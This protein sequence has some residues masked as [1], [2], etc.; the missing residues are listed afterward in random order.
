MIHDT[1]DRVIHPVWLWSGVLLLVVGTVA[2]Q[3]ALVLAAAL[4]LGVVGVAYLWGRRALTAVSYRRHLSQERAAWGDGV[5]LSVRVENRKLLPLPWLCIEDEMPAALVIRTVLTSSHLAERRRLRILSSVLWYQQVTRRYTLLCTARGEHVF[6]PAELRSG[7]IFGLATAWLTLPERTTLL[8]YP[9]V[10]SPSALG[11][12]PAQPFGPLRTPRRLFDDPLRTVGIRD[13]AVG[14]SLRSMH[15]KATARTGAPQVRVPEPVRTLRAVIFLDV[16]TGEH[17][18]DGYDPDLLELA[19]VTAASTAM[20]LLAE[21]FE[22]GLITNGRALGRPGVIG[23]A[24]SHGPATG[25]AILEELARLGP[26]SAAPLDR[27]ILFER[28]QLPGQC[29]VI[30]V[31]AAPGIALRSAVLR[32][33]TDGRYVAL[34]CVGGTRLPAASGGLTVRHVSANQDW[35]HMPALTVRG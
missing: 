5:V 4:L 11:L 21:G 6:G 3:S 18:W 25:P 29:S 13:Y 1:R 7:D 33:H 23:V 24:P 34:V 14:D 31:T 32:L 35:R 12:P 30:V 2:R 10:V 28:G 20:Y 17:A 16:A 19:I 26:L 15:W 22:V 27:V 8:V 9:R